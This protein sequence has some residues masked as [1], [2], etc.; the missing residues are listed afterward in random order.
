VR[1]LGAVLVL[2]VAGT[3]ERA[4]ASAEDIAACALTPSSQ[5]VEPPS[6]AGRFDMNRYD[7]VPYGGSVVAIVDAVQACTGTPD[8]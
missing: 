4:E 7:F 6:I 3:V 1:T 5:Q 2:L 8:K